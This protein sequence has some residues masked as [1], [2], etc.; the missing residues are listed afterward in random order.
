MSQ[1]YST[2]TE[3]LWEEKDDRS[4]SADG[5]FYLCSTNGS[6]ECNIRNGLTNFK[7]WE[8]MKSLLNI[9]LLFC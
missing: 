7:A 3:V 2:G 5:T 4:M 1:V 9:V 8:I 6:V